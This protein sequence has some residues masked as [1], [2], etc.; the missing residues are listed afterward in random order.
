M[1]RILGV[2]L[3]IFSERFRRLVDA[4][5]KNIEVTEGNES[6]IV[7]LRKADENDF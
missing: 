3:Y 2:L 6:V 7:L 4:K 5:R 1:T